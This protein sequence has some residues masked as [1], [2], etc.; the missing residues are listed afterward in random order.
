MPSSDWGKVE[1]TEMRKPLTR[2]TAKRDGKSKTMF[3]SAMQAARAKLVLIKGDGLDGVTFT[4]AGE[5]HYAGRGDVDLP[6]GDDPFLSPVHVNFL[7]RDGNMVVRDENSAN[8]VFIRIRGSHPIK[9]GDRFLVGEQVL[10][11][12]KT[13]A[14]DD[15]LEA[16]ADGTYF[17]ASRRLD[18][19]FRLVQ[20][21][22]GGDT[23][24]GFQ[25]TS[26]LVSLGRESN[27][28]N[29]ADDPFISGHHAQV[30]YAEGRLNLT[31]L[32]SKNG[33]FLKVNN[34]AV[35]QHGDY[36]FMGQQ[37]LRVEIV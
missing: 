17:Y 19:H 25:A 14:S 8:G 24:I 18:S 15:P 10:E 30:T 26:D 31:D 12:Q 6:F 32:G 2:P 13:I 7:Y 16:E 28:I 3:F 37:L 33:T 29:F 5:N 1:N 36:V 21:L 20:I 35:L 34:E 23:G 22:R 11:V 9:F 4:L 27:D